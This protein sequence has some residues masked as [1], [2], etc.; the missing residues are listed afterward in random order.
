MLTSVGAGDVG[1]TADV[2]GQLGPMQLICVVLVPR[3]HAQTPGAIYE[4][5]VNAVTQSAPQG[6]EILDVSVASAAC[7]NADKRCKA[8]NRRRR[9]VGRINVSLDSHYPVVRELSVPLLIALF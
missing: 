3:S 1:G 7:H 9:D 2:A 4:H 8:S 6:A 5:I